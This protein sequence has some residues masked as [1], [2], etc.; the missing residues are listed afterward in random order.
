VVGVGVTVRVFVT[1]RVGVDVR[2]TVAVLVFVAVGVVVRVLVAVEVGVGS[3]YV[4]C[5]Q[6]VTPAFVVAWLT[7]LPAPLVLKLAVAVT[8]RVTLPGPLKSL[9]GR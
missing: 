5:T 1:V 6:M 4:Y 3:K 7:T 2:V 9:I 8:G